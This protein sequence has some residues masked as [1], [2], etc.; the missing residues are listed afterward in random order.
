MTDLTAVF[1]EEAEVG[2][3]SSSGRSSPFD[4]A[5]TE[6]VEAAAAAAALHPP[7]V[8]YGA[9]TFLLAGTVI[10]L[11]VWGLPWS[12]GVLHEYWAREM[13]PGEESTLTLAATLQTGAMYMTAAIGPLFTT[14]PQY[15]KHMQV[16]G[17][18]VASI[19]LIASAFVTRASHLIVTL[20]VLYPFAGALYLPCATLL[21][22]WFHARRG[23]ATGIMFAGTGVGGTIFPFVT[24]ALL[25]RYGYR[26]TMVSIGIAFAGL[27]AIALVFVKRRIPV[28]RRSLA[29]SLKREHRRKTDW[30]F[31]RHR[32]IWIG[33]AIILSTSMGN[34]LPSLWMPSYAEAVRAHA[35]DGT[36][37]VA[38]MNA[39]SVPGNTLTGYLSDRLPTR[40]V[41]TLS[42]TLAAFACLCL[43]GLGTSEGLL[44]GFSVVW[45][46][47]AL[48]MVGT[49]SKMITIISKDDP[50]LPTFS[51][52]FF[53][54]L[55]GV[56][57]LTSGP[58]S[59]ALLSKGPIGGKGAYGATNYGGLLIYTGV[60]ALVG[61][62]PAIFFPTK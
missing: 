23:L 11:L 50:T 42:C 31:W 38:I 20:G 26:A 21:Y 61:G 5:G 3:P 16:L 44:V 32:S 33:T 14:F 7:D 24:S 56:G 12:V 45:G 8:G 43:W 17:M 27:N 46:V 22:E 37:L 49:W 57:N 53:T 55:K 52:S 54:I 39:A 41:V 34:F 59:T 51:F 35:P 60:M 58:I 15:T 28:P 2:T 40:I 30:S 62:V 18:I 1:D 13:F 10:E 9:W 4:L 36:A 25:Q 19:G 47:T 48:S 29:S 6:G